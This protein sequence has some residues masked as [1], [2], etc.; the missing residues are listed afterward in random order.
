MVIECP[1]M[2]E[3]RRGCDLGSFID[4]Y[5][6]MRHQFSPVKIYALYLSDKK[7]SVVKSRAISLSHMKIGWH[8]L[9]NIEI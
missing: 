9:M 6:G 1:A 5:R 7:V 8:K 4:L 3:Y 2:E